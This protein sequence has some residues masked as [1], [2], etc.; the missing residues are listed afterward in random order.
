MIKGLH[1]A[2]SGSDR[3]TQLL[4]LLINELADLDQE[5]LIE[6]DDYH[7]A[8][9]PEVDSILTFLR[10]YLPPRVPLGAPDSRGSTLPTEPAQSKGANPWSE[11]EGAPCGAFEEA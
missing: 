8:S 5:L 11:G 6:L 4:T 2:E 10:D 7:R 3:I 1:R 9:V